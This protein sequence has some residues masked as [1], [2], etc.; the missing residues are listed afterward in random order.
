LSL[1]GLRSSGGRG[2]DRTSFAGERC[3]WSSLIRSA[4]GR[5]TTR[6]GDSAAEGG[7]FRSPLLSASCRS[8]LGGRGTACLPFSAADCRLATSSPFRRPR[9]AGGR[10]TTRRGDSADCPRLASGVGGRST[11]ALR[12]GA[13]GR[14]PVSLSRAKLGTGRSGG[15]SLLTTLRSNAWRGGSIAG[16]RSPPSAVH[17]AGVR[18]GRFTTC[19]PRTSFESMRQPSRPIGREWRIA[20]SEA[21]VIPCF[22][23]MKRIGG[24]P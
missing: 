5:G 22:S 3:G 24:R 15:L 9:S 14:M 13:F 11:R 2:T 23:F 7:V 8:A 12:S 4:G 6:R 19:A 20:S 17:F 10:G 21:P 18:S 16:R 1:E